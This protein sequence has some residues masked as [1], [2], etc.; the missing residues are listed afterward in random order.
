MGMRWTCLTAAGLLA[1]CAAEPESGGTSFGTTEPPPD[2]TTITAAGSTTDGSTGD[3]PVTSTTS[4]GSTDTGDADASSTGGDTTEG[5]GCDEPTVFYADADGDGFGD[6]ASP[7]EACEA[8]PG[9]VDDDTDCDDAL[10]MVNP[11]ADELCDGLD[12]DCDGILDEFSAASDACDDCELAQRESSVYWF[13]PGP[14]NRFAARDFCLDHG[15]DLTS[16]DGLP[17]DSFVR[18]NLTGSLDWFIGL[19][20]LAVEG[21]W[22]WSDGSPTVYFAWAPGE[23]NNLDNENCVELALE[24][25]YNWNDTNCENI[26]S[27]VCEAVEPIVR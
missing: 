25:S 3:V 1:A 22:E 14:L 5:A 19:E 11:L 17:E 27:F 7:M 10:P 12:N 24:D 13:C 26:Q 21:T 15:A 18:S 6:P 4:G 16:I 23:P 8:P 2:P 20:D 9:H